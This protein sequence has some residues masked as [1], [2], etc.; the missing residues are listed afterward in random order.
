MPG[1]RRRSRRRRP[2]TAPRGA[3]RLEP[4]QAGQVAGQA[5]R[6]ADARLP[7]R[8]ANQPDITLK[9]SSPGTGLLQIDVFLK[10]DLH[11]NMDVSA[12][13]VRQRAHARRR[14][15]SRRGRQR[16]RGVPCADYFS[17]LSERRAGRASRTSASSGSL[18]PA[19]VTPTATEF[20]GDWMMPTAPRAP[21]RRRGHGLRRCSTTYRLS[22]TLASETSARHG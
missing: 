16:G 15:S 5:D 10:L 21:A 3:A 9:S 17:G 20:D 22:T 2:Q 18:K 12:P 13:R 6:P 11:G 19:I 8:L 7:G 4:V 1:R 14:L